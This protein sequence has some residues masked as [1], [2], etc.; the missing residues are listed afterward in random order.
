MMLALKTA[1]FPAETVT[2]SGPETMVAGA[3][4]TRKIMG[5]LVAMPA[6]LAA[7]A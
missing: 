5:G 6:K 2:D 4:S 7:V 3:G 1:G